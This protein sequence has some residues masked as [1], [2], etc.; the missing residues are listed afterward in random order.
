MLK[1]NKNRQNRR[2]LWI[3]LILCIIL[4]IT[5]F[6][7]LLFSR[8][9][10]VFKE[11][12][13][14]LDKNMYSEAIV[15]FDAAL[16]LRKSIGAREIEILKY[17]AEA[18][19]MLGDLN[20]STY[21]YSILQKNNGLSDELQSV[22]A[23]QLLQVGE[24]EKAKEIIDRANHSE[25][26]SK[27]LAM[28]ADA[29]MDNQEYENALAYLALAGENDPTEELQREIRQREIA[30]YEYLGNYEEAL[31]RA[32]AYITEYG[33]DDKIRHEIVFLESRLQ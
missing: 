9:A 32:N 12:V 3:P 24:I 11:G 4:V 21:T 25:L 13:A 29:Y 2:I 33:E 27:T 14:Y 28:L 17:R 6:H 15:K 18:E 26:Y 19:T 22:Y 1:T 20:S 16:E 10:R 8:Q 7:T 30:C 31:N 5:L 23:M